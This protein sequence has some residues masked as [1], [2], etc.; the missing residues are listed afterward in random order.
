ML[1]TSP[2]GDRVRFARTTIRRP[3]P[4]SARRVRCVALKGQTR[5]D[6]R[7]S[8]R[9]RCSG[10]SRKVPHNSS[11]VRVFRHRFRD[12]FIDA[13]HGKVGLPSR[14]C[15]N[16]RCATSDARFPASAQVRFWRDTE[17][18]RSALPSVRVGGGSCASS[19]AGSATLSP[20]TVHGR[21]SRWR[22]RV[23]FHARPS[24]S[25][26]DPCAWQE[27]APGQAAA[28]RR[29]GVRTFSR[30]PETTTQVP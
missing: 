14:C 7:K 17:A 18:G 26:P 22:G 28:T 8:D 10:A 21:R 4:L 29:W 12:G 1:S 5:E 25:S 15:E 19:A 2:N 27:V 9:K 20:W 3:N 30:S 13:N 11:S 16:P 6:R 23:P 24:A